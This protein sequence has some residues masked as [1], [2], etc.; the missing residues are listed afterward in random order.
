MIS[1][2]WDN[3]KAGANLRA[4][5]VSF[6]EAKSVFFDDYAIQYFDEDHSDDAE[7]RFLMLGMSNLS[8]ILLVVHWFRASDN[9]IRIISARKA[10]KKEQSEYRG[11]SL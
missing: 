3:R 2:E 9:V 4:H 6:E 7:E 10:T 8:R 11:P 5:G 1:F